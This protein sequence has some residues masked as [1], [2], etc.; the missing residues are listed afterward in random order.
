MSLKISELENKKIAVHNTACALDKLLTTDDISPLPACSG[1]SILIVGSSGSGKSTLLHSIM[2]KPKKNGQ[3]QSY[4]NLF[5]RIYVI[6]PTL[7]GKS[8]KGDK[9]A[10]LPEDQIYRELSLDVLDELEEKLYENKEE[11]LH[12]CVVMDDIGSQLKSRGAKC[13]KKLVQMLQNRRHVACSYITLLQKFKDCPNGIRSNTSHLA[14]FR[15]RNRIEKEAVMHEL[16]PYDNKKNEQIFA[17][18]FD[19]EKMKFPFMFIDMSLKKS[20]KYLF[21]SGFNPLMI[22]EET[23]P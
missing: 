17:H 6:S 15:P 10:S 9:F 16:M 8:V 19:N 20:N 7:G 11:G 1:F 2:T 4:K 14:F 23:P 22:D 5:D 12:S 21:Y 13:E 18:I 3:R